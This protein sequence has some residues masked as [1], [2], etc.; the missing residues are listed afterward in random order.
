[1]KQKKLDFLRQANSLTIFYSKTIRVGVLL[2]NTA[3]IAHIIEGDM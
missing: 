3:I 2:S 1:M